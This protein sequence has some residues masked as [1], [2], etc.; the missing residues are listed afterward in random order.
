MLD[1]AFS[2][3]AKHIA[4]S[5]YAVHAM[6]YPGFGLSEGLH[7]YVP[8]FNDLVDDVIEHYRK[9]KGVKLFFDLFSISLSSTS[10]IGIF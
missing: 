4:R 5:G 9:I 1:L 3:I 8:C 2:G 6:D 7:G 10:V